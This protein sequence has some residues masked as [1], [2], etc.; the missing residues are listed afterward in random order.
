MA[1]ETRAA[2]EELHILDMRVNHSEQFD[3]SFLLKSNRHFFVQVEK[4]KNMIEYLECCGV[5]LNVVSSILTVNPV[6]LLSK[7]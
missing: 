4:A 1:A 6:E 7:K 3:K 2:C 5:H